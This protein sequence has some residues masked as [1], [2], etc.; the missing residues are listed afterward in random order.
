MD[1]KVDSKTKERDQMRRQFTRTSKKLEDYIKNT[2]ISSAIIEYEYLK[3]CTEKIKMLDNVIAEKMIDGDEHVY[4]EECDQSANFR[5]IYLTLKYKMDKLIQSKFTK[6]TTTSNLN[7]PKIELLKFDDDPRKW[8][9]FWGQFKKIHESNTLQPEDKFQYLLQ[10]LKEGSKA[11]MLV[12][13]FPSSAANYIKAI[14][15]LK[16]RFAKEEI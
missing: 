16:D 10:G 6:E 1:S 11:K 5:K 4:N 7:L 13:S 2:E 3:E 8:I 9:A 15:E 12:S 14:E